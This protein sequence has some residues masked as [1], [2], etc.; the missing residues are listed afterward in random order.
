MADNTKLPA[1]VAAVVAA[2]FLA[3]TGWLIYGRSAG[4]DD[5]FAQCRSGQ[6][7]G[8]AVGGPFTLVDGSTG[9]TVTD[10]D[11]ISKPTLVYFGYTFCPD[12]CPLDMSRNAE[13]ADILEEQGLD[14]R[15]AFITVDPARDTEEAVAGFAANIHPKAI[16]LTG[17]EEQIRTAANAYK[18]YYKKQEAEDEFYLVD[19]SAFTYLM[20]PGSG[21]LDF[22]KH[23]A[24]ADEVAKSVACYLSVP[25]GRN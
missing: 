9:Q 1:A 17:S 5:A 15:L 18:A 12:V 19:H 7:G 6:V 4:G 14:I 23:A 10:A 13:V 16:G 21:F 8:G 2:G 20:L 25:D 3:W 22:Y 24:P 11:V